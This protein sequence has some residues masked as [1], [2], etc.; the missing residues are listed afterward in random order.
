MLVQTL[1]RIKNR[2]GADVFAREEIAAGNIVGT[3]PVSRPV[4]IVFARTDG[5]AAARIDDADLAVFPVR[6]GLR[7]IGQHLLRR[8]AHFEQPQ[9]EPAEPRLDH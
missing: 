6:I 2:I 9:R 4:P 8:V 7:H 5:H 1:V 3:D